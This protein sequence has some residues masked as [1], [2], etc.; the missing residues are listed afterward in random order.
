VAR[1]VGTSVALFGEI[2]AKVGR[3]Q[4]LLSA[5]PGR[6]DVWSPMDCEKPTADSALAE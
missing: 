1:V 4:L 5:A 3:L 2:T 6:A